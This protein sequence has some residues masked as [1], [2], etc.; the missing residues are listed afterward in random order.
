MLVLVLELELV[1]LVLV[2]RLVV[3]LLFLVLRLLLLVLVLV[4]PLLVLLLLPWRMAATR[5][6]RR[7]WPRR[8]RPRR[9][10]W[11]TP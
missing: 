3:L 1:R 2:V 7:P 5:R 10:L 11:R 8:W 6:Q 4:L 9:G